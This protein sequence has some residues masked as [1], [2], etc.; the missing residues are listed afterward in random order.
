MPTLVPASPSWPE[1][2]LAATAPTV[3]L[4]GSDALTKTWAAREPPGGAHELAR[5]D[6]VDAGRAHRASMSHEIG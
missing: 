6:Q 3:A 2:R 4:S 1:S 5:D